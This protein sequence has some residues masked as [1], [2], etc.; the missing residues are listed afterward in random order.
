MKK[1]FIV[2]SILLI[3]IFS[4]RT[5]SC[6]GGP[7]QKFGR[8][9]ANIATGWL[10]VFLASHAT[11]KKCESPIGFIAGIPLGL[12]KAGIRTTIG[13]YETLTFPFAGSND[14]APIIKPEFVTIKRLSPFS[15][16]EDK[17]TYEKNY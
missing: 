12:V 17:L 5:A 4:A 10:E 14:Y 7:A 13:L 1:I 15:R 16:R 8:G 6:A 2:F 9:I 3:I 11:M